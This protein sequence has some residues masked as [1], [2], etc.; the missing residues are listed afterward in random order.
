MPEELSQNDLDA[1]LV[2]RDDSN[3]RKVRTEEQERIN[4]AF[5]Y[6]KPKG[7]QPERYEGIRKTA[8]AFAELLADYCPESRELSTAMTHLETV[9]MFANAA[10]AR[11]E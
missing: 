6:H 10:I 5:V 2:R 7:T 3:E 11:N 8:K 9:V 4:K 1:L